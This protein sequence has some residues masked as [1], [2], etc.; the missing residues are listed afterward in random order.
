MKP[1][2]IHQSHLL[3]FFELS[4]RI[5]RGAVP[6]LGL[7]GGPDSRAALVSR[8]SSE[9]GLTPQQALLC[10]LK[11]CGWLA[12]YLTMT[13]PDMGIA[14]LT[15]AGPVYQ[16]T[17]SQE[18]YYSEYV[19]AN[20][21][22][23]ASVLYAMA[24]PEIRGVRLVVDSPG[25]TVTGTFELSRAIRM[26]DEAKPTIGVCDNMAASAGYAIYTGTKTLFSSPS[27]FLASIGVFGTHV[28]QKK[29][30]ESWY[31]T[32]LTLIRDGDRKAEHLMEM[33]PE[34][35]AQALL[36]VQAFGSQF[37]EL[38]NSNR[39]RIIDPEAMQGQCMS[40]QDALT[41]GLVDYVCDDPMTE[42][43]AALESMLK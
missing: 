35:L 5:Q 26:L 7:H 21:L 4:A 8:L 41:A 40:G 25:G 19:I 27:A 32:T 39:G 12:P 17:E 18:C 23:M 43:L 30:I 13:R 3:Q 34:M 24:N 28:D 31:N 22:A 2:L 9:D 29:I 11:E 36:E 33:T 20:R 14:T 10:E 16:L 37:R 42:A 15:L 38:V 6:E 1:L